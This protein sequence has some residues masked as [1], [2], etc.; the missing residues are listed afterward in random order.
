MGPLGWFYFSSAIQLLVIRNDMTKV[1][2]VSFFLLLKEG[3]FK[4]ILK[5]FSILLPKKTNKKL[6]V[7]FLFYRM[8]SQTIAVQ[9]QNWCFSLNL[10]FNILYKNNDFFKYLQPLSWRSWFLTACFFYITW[11]L[12]NVML[13]MK[14]VHLNRTS[15]VVIKGGPV[16]KL[17]LQNF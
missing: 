4:T 10:T 8:R 12:T 17:S 5:L 9:S 6:I 11:L 13:Q 16:V 1:S 2:S 7:F 15:R 3:V 14:C